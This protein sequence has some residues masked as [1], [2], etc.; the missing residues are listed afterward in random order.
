MSVLAITAS[1]LVG[2][3]V[4]ETIL[5]V[6]SYRMNAREGGAGSVKTLL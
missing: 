6:L 5:F 4:V 3:W 2:V 1:I